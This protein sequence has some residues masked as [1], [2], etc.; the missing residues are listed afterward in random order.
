MR[1]SEGRWVRPAW[2]WDGQ[3]FW[4]RPSVGW[5][6]DGRILAIREDGP[7]EEIDGLLLPGLINGHVHLEIGAQATLPGRGLINWVQELR[8]RGQFGTAAAGRAVYAAIKLGTAAVVDVGNTG[9][10]AAVG[11]AAQLPGLYFREILGIDQAEMPDLPGPLTPHAPYSTHPGR[12][13]GC[14]R[15]G[16]WTMHVDED[17]EESR[18]LRTGEGGWAEYVRALGRDLSQWEAPGVGPIAML[19]QLGVLGPMGLLAHVTCTRGA[20]LDLLG[21]SG[22]WV[23]LCPR[24]NLHITGRLPDLRGIVSRR[25]PFL[26]GTDSLASVEDLDL[27]QEAAVLRRAFPDLPMELWLEALTS[28]GGDWLGKPL[29]RLLPGTAPGVLHVEIPDPERLF[30]GTSWKRRWL[31]CPKV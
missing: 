17:P 1:S 23:V 30:D 15:R 25:I 21:Q 14:A 27:L 8:A 29:G 18:F 16:R 5:D 28:R 9:E 13:V 3:R 11:R 10:V 7:G 19:R 31:A 6:G 4:K 20:E 22:A 26:L 12:I 24:S 2:A